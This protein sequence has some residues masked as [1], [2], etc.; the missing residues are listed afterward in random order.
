MCRAGRDTGAN[1]SPDG[2]AGP[3]ASQQQQAGPKQGNSGD[4]SSNAAQ[5][6]PK[7]GCMKDMGSF[8]LPVASLPAADEQGQRDR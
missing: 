5:T 6:K 7:K 2:A 1:T 4:S 3:S 8:K